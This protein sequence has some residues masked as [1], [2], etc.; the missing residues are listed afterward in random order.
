MRSLLVVCHDRL[1]PKLL[2][3][4]SVCSQRHNFNH[5][6]SEEVIK[7]EELAY[8]WMYSKLERHPAKPSAAK[9]EEGGISLLSICPLSL[10]LAAVSQLHLPIVTAHRQDTLQGEGQSLGGQVA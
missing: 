7:I 1:I 8:R 2:R 6:G 10:S 3:Q 9:R 4:I 5:S